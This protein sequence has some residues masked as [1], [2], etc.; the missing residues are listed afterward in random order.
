MLMLNILRDRSDQR[1]WRLFAVESCIR[2]IDLFGYAEFV[3]T[4]ECGSKMAEGLAQR[5]D[6]SEA[7]EIVNWWIGQPSETHYYLAEAVQVMILPHLIGGDQARIVVRSIGD[8]IASVKFDSRGDE[9]YAAQSQLLREIFGTFYPMAINPSWLT[10]TIRSLAQGIYTDRAFDRLSILAD[11][12]QDAGCD[13]DDMLTHCRS[14]GPH[15]RG[16]WAVDLILG[17]A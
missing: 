4:V 17:K 5:V 11:A 13:N 8:A 15:V 7:Q 12:L 2:A 1:K 16:C 10:S 14:D 3:P 9:E 6:P